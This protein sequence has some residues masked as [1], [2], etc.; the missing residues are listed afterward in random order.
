[1]TVDRGTQLTVRRVAISDAGLRAC[2]LRQPDSDQ[3]DG[4]AA[5][6]LLAEIA[7]MVEESDDAARAV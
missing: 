1:M 5:P 3:K 2:G 7:P 4:R 6:F